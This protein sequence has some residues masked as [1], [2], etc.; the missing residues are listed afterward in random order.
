MVRKQNTRYISLAVDNLYITKESR[1]DSDA[2]N[3][4]VDDR[5]ASGER[6]AKHLAHPR[7]MTSYEHTTCLHQGEEDSP[8]PPTNDT[9]AKSPGTSDSVHK[10]L[11]SG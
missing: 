3:T 6:P 11:A 9:R 10:T 7:Y 8:E 1:S 2:T 4:D 5:D